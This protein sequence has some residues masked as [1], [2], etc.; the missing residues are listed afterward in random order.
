MG[1]SRP[2]AKCH[3]PGESSGQPAATGANGILGRIQGQYVAEATSRLPPAATTT[4]E[5]VEI[6]LEAGCWPCALLRREES[7]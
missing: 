2:A 7:C 6:E 5:H 4:D 1:N 3:P